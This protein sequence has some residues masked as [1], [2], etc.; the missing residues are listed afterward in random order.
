PAAEST[1]TPVVAPPAEDV[2]FGNSGSTSQSPPSPRNSSML[3]PTTFDPT[4]SQA[5]P[6]SQDEA[7][8]IPPPRASS[9]R[10][11]PS[12]DDEGEDLAFL[13]PNAEAFAKAKRRR[14][15]DQ[16][17]ANEDVDM[18]EDSADEEAEADARS[19]PPPK[20]SASA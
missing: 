1:P 11:H 7:E 20:V 9:K 12:S 18:V 8:N 10:P 5:I 16:A 6:D 3:D 2:S 14:L 15:A 17:A 13:A 19:M 4:S